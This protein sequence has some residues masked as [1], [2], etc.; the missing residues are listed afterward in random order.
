MLLI[1]FEKIFSFLKNKIQ[2]F[3]GR[4]QKLKKK[5]IYIYKN[6]L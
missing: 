1:I 2:I 5:R 3:K 6:K 4:S